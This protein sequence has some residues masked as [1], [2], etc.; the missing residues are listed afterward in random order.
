MTVSDLTPLLDK[1]LSSEPRSPADR[2][3]AL[4]ALD[5]WLASHGPL[6]DPHLRHYLERRSYLKAQAWLHAR[7]GE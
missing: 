5:A 2:V 4:R 3:A 1:V 7:S 6:L